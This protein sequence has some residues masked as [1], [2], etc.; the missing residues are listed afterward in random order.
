MNIFRSLLI[1][2]LAG[3]VLVACSESEAGNGDPDD[4]EIE[5]EAGESPDEGLVAEPVNVRVTTLEPESFDDIIEVIGT[6]RAAEDIMVASE[7][8]GKVV[9]WY[10]SKGSYVRKGQTLARMDADVLRA[11]LEAAEAQLKIAKLDAEKKAE[12]LESGA[13]PEVTATTAAYSLEAAEAQVKLLKTRIGKKTVHAPVSGRIDEKIADLGEM[14]GPGGPVARILQTGVVEIEA[15]VPERYVGD[16]RV[17]TPVEMVFDGLDGRRM[18]GRITY[19][20]TGMDRG[21]R[22]L[23]VEIAVSNPGGSLKPG[24]VAEIEILRDRLRNVVVVPRTALVRVEEGYQVYVA[25]AEGGGH[26][27]EARDVTLGATDRGV[28][29]ITDGLAPGERIIAVGQNKVSPGERIAIG[30]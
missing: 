4:P 22:T 24:M 3:T 10:V 16:L 14:V 15:G 21:D 20:G 28:V 5:A 25:R 1:L 29:V 9:R 2:L 7:E 6:V 18:N 26:V 27:A 30:E 17:G 11:Q 13:I 23:P 8:G 12:V 19:I